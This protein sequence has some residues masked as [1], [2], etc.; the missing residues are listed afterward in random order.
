MNKHYFISLLHKY[1]KGESTR[2]E[3][4]FVEK[5]YNLFQSDPDILDMLKSNEKKALKN[6]LIDSI[7]DNIYKSE[8]ADKKVRW[9]N[10]RYVKL[11][12]AAMLTTVLI[13]SAYL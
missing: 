3:Q 6:S 5:Y 11:A 1:L 12:A 4:V 13:S 2:E 9:I 8:Q 7:R 10:K